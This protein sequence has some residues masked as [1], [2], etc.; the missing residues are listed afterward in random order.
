MAEANESVI[1][2]GSFLEEALA[3]EGLK[4]TEDTILIQHGLFKDI[5]IKLTVNVPVDVILMH[6]FMFGNLLNSDTLK[7]SDGYADIIKKKG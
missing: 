5:P 4:L 7:N 6:P 3:K 1:K 2:M